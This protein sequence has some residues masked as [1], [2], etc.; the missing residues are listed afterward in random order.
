M[1]PNTL[2]RKV[3]FPI[4]E[5]RPMQKRLRPLKILAEK[6]KLLPVSKNMETKL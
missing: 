1:L 3:S 2:L 4:L 5:K 6:S